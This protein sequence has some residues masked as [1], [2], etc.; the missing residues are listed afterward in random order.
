MAGRL[1]DEFH[2]FKFEEAHPELVQPVH[3]DHYAPQVEGF[4]GAGYSF[5][6]MQQAHLGMDVTAT[7]EVLGI[8][9]GEDDQYPAAPLF[10]PMA[11]EQTRL[12]LYMP[13][14]MPSDYR[15][16]YEAYT[17]LIGQQAPTKRL[18]DPFLPSP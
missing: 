14:P 10:D 11:P 9:P 17:H 1:P 3:Y 12:D 16:P 8:H 5:E 13:S 7:R 2:N 18:L 15:S 4:F 6:D